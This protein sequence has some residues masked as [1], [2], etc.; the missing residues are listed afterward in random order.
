MARI[1]QR[2]PTLLPATLLRPAALLALLVFAP[3]SA[4]A[5]AV[6]TREQMVEALVSHN[7]SPPI[8][9][10][11][12]RQHVAEAAHSRSRTDGVKLPPIAPELSSRSQIAVPILFDTDTP[13]IEPESYEAV[14]RIADAMVHASLLQNDFLIVAHI[15][16][17]GKH[18]ANLVLSQRRADAVRDALVNTF[19][20]S[21]RRIMAIGAGEEQLS[22]SHPDANAKGDIAIVN[23]TD[24]NMP[25][26]KPGAETTE[27]P[28]ASP[29]PPE[30]RQ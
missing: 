13:I 11:R 28:A 7:P 23:M 2:R 10:A 30:N 6:P 19:R 20:I 5:Q 29:R 9:L 21:A 4:S 12:L 22:P 24:S 18:E 15:S 27:Q 26:A 1:P 25:A 3:I 16:P 8:D 14:G 17:S